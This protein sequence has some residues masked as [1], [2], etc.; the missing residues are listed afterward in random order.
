MKKINYKSLL[1]A[2]YLLIFVMG[3]VSC[4]SSDKRLVVPEEMEEKLTAELSKPLEVV[5]LNKDEAGKID[6][7][8][9][10][11]I[12]RNIDLDRAK[13]NESKRFKD[14]VSYIQETERNIPIYIK[15]DLNLKE[16]KKEVPKR[17]ELKSVDTTETVLKIKELKEVE[18]D[19]EDIEKVKPVK[20]VY[21][22]SP[23]RYSF[24]KL[25]D[26][27]PKRKLEKNKAIELAK[28]FFEINELVKI[29]EF[30]KYGEIVVYE[31]R[32]D[33]GLHGSDSTS[34]DILLMQGVKIKRMYMDKPVVNS[35]ISLDFNPDT[36]E[37]FGLKHYNWTLMK[38][39]SEVP[40]QKEIAKV[41]DK[42][43]DILE[44]TAKK[45]C[46]ENEKAILKNITSAWFQTETELI[47]ILVCEIEVG[48]IDTEGAHNHTYIQYINLAGSDDVFNPFIKKEYESPV[49]P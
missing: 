4:E 38:Q 24:R 5:S 35:R 19:K 39:G 32:E 21:K 10:V 6:E 37:I 49:T 9:K 29:N 14:R 34:K 31:I 42:V 18:L 40:V 2:G 1:A 20:M 28:E 12:S 15:K 43:L 41:P 3:F 47:P 27:E 45:Y 22:R 16:L 36:E 13:K 25:V 33:R 23:G 11:L 26:V 8:F 48:D 46:D 30:D 44:E 7:T 17:K